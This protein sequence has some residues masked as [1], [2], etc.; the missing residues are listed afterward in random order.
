MLLQAFWQILLLRSS[1]QTIPYSTTL[2]GITLLLHLLMGVV[3]GAIN[4]PLSESIAPAALGTLLV[5]G[6]PYLLLALY[7]LL[8]R[9]VQ[10][11]TAMAGCEVLIGLMS[12]PF[13]LWLVSVEKS[14]AALP[15]LF[16]LLLFGWN[17]VVVGY[18]LRHALGV[19]KAQ[20]LLFAVGYVSISIILSSLIQAP[21][22]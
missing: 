12:L 19:S 18:I 4:Q 1:P 17:V 22:G 9:L 10:T 15:A 2:L 14:S 16:M 20:G 13:N 21:E 8:N 5:A 7:G 6:F 11:V 3:F